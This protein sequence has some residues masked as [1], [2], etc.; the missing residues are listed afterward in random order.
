MT[1]WAACGDSVKRSTAMAIS[2][3]GLIRW[4]Q[5]LT[6]QDVHQLVQRDA[7]VPQVGARLEQPEVEREAAGIDLLGQMPVRALVQVLGVGAQLLRGPRGLVGRGLTSDGV[8]QDLVDQVDVRKLG[9]GVGAAQLDVAEVRSALE[10]HVEGRLVSHRPVGLRDGG[11]GGRSVGLDLDGRLPPDEL[12]QVHVVRGGTVHRAAVIA[13]AGAERP[14]QRLPR[15]HG[16]GI[17]HARP[18][19]RPSHHGG[20]RADQRLAV[21]A[22]HRERDRRRLLGPVEDGAGGGR[23]AERGAKRSHER[24]TTAPDGTLRRADAGGG[25]RGDGVQTVDLGREPVEPLH[26]L[27]P[28][29]EGGHVG[30]ALQRGAAVVGE[31]AV[32][33]GGESEA[34]ILLEKREQRLVVLLPPAAQ[35]GDDRRRREGALQRRPQR[36]GVASRTLGRRVTG[37]GRRHAA[38]LDEREP[39]LV[40]E[41]DELLDGLEVPDPRPRLKLLHHRHVAAGERAQLQGELELPHPLGP[42]LRVF[43]QGRPVRLGRALVQGEAR[44]HTGLRVA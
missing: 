34:G 16:H 18:G 9:V 7:Q 14:E 30:D 10:Q 44:E 40:G 24:F 39:L 13:R 23:P 6:L 28:P 25:E 4:W 21:L 5:A 41:R 19:R 8:L 27:Q 17:G 29:R 35:P 11:R 20:R 36:G 3:E 32:D 31:I 38:P 15:R 26:A 22:E 2:S 12:Q 37:H 42:D 1:M 43:L 33:V